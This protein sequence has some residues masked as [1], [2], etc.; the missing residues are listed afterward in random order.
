MTV[1][2]TLDV[3]VILGGKFTSSSITTGVQ[4]GGE[5]TILAGRCLGKREESRNERQEE[6]TSE[7]GKE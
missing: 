3:P 4:I 6:R 5:E 7:I 2:I 1:F